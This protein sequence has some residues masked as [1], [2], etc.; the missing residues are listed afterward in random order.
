MN[1]LYLLIAGSRGFTENGSSYVGNELLSNFDIMSTLIDGRLDATK[2][3]SVCIV[4]GGA[5][6]YCMR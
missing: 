5:P 2:C 6:W 1:K 4:H 3:D